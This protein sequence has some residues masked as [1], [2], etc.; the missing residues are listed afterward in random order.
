MPR[1]DKLIEKD[2][3]CML[4]TNMV[5]LIGKLPSN[6]GNQTAGTNIV[7]GS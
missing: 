5:K 7:A 4:T 1:R 2:L 3:C 6:F